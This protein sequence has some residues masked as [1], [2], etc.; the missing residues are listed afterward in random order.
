MVV[1]R[2]GSLRT[3]VGNGRVLGN[4]GLAIGPNR[5]RTVV[6]PGKSKGDA[7][8]SILIKGPTFRMAG[9]DMAFSKGGLL[10]L[11][12]R[13]HD[14]RNLFLDFRCPMRVP[15]MDVM[16]FVHTTMGRRHG[17]GKLPTLATD[18][19]LGLV[20]RG[21][22]IMRLSGGLTGH[23]IGR[24]FSNNRGGQGRVFR[25]TVLRPHLDVLSRASSNLSVSTL[26]VMTRKIGGLGAPSADCVIVARCRHLLSCVGPSVM[27]ILCGNHV[28][29]ATKPRLTL[30][31]RRGK[32]S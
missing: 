17:C 12:P 24:N 29:G 25:V 6:K 16:G 1:L 22:T 15:K 19:F 21:H 7:L 3:D 32:C 18:R 11:D 28:I 31:L 26:H 30:R 9:N 23:S 27:R 10:S 5:M 8:S 4:V 2:V 13:S 14:R 20:H